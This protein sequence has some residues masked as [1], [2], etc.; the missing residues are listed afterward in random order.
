MSHNIHAEP[1]GHGNSP[2]AWTLVFIMIIGA[3]IA[4]VAFCLANATL[5]WAG[6]AVMGLGLVVG[7]GMRKAGYGVN[8]HKLTPSRH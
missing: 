2:A 4:S 3:A 8:G 1:V 5:F 6:I 7:F